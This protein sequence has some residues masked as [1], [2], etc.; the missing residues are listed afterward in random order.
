MSK[1]ELTANDLEY[2]ADM[3]RAV[4]FF[5]EDIKKVSAQTLEE[6]DACLHVAEAALR[7]AITEINSGYPNQNG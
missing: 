3:L 1:N 7:R 6:L 5:K 2:V 4:A